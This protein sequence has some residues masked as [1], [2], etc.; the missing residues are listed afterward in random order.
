[1]MRRIALD[2][3]PAARLAVLRALV[4]LDGQSTATIARASGLHW[5]VAHRHCEDM[6]AVG[7]V[8]NLSEHDDTDHRWTLS[9]EE[10]DLIRKVIGDSA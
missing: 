8:D 5:Y 1:M 10:G 6:A 9:G 3:M 7:V 2:S 4:A